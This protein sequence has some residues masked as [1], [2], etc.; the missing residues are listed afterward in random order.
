LRYYRLCKGFR[1]AQ[2]AILAEYLLQPV[3][4]IGIE[5]AR[6]CGAVLLAHT[7]V[8]WPLEPVAESPRALIKLM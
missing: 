1:I 3:C 7:H 5:Y 2:L 4:I 6:G 8:Q